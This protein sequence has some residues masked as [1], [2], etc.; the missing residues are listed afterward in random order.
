MNAIALALTDSSTMLRRNL[1]RMRRYPSMTLL[2]IGLPVLFLLLFV[3]VFGGT[4]GAGL[5]TG[6]VAG[7]DSRAEYLTYV[8]PAILLMAAAS[9]AQGTAISIAMDRTEGIFARFRTMAISPSSVLTGHVLGAVIQSLLAMGVLLGV[10]VL[11][12]FRPDPNPL[13]WLALLCL[14]TFT[15]FALTW[16]CVAFGLVSKSVETASNLPMFLVILPFLS[17][18][19]VP[20][21]SMPA[22]LAWFAEHQPFTP[23]I[24]TV[25]G[26]FTGN[27]DGGTALVAVGWCAL[28]ALVSYLWARKLYRRDPAG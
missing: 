1:L 28:I 5:S 19:F 24:E 10:S 4:L 22:G 15:A 21:E 3:Y 18:G 23:I 14:L 7:A 26:L 13:G 2:L 25:R 20:V 17:S 6:I 8:T 12:G 27:A 9:A 16:L 11:L